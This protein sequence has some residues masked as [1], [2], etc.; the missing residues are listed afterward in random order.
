MAK[1]SGDDGA[2]IVMG[3]DG[4]TAQGLQVGTCVREEARWWSVAGFNT[5]PRAAPA[6]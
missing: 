5:A 3:S 6:Q 4:G 1:P 2:N